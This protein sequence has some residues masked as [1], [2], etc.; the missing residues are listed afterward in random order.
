MY[1]AE[2]RVA[3]EILCL[4]INV[5]AFLLTR[6]LSAGGGSTATQTIVPAITIMA[7]FLATHSGWLER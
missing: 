7:P 4:S 3:V 6:I 2:R 5:F 1:C